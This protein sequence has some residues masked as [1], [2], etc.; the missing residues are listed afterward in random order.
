MHITLK[1]RNFADFYVIQLRSA[2][3]GHF[4]RCIAETKIGN[5]NTRVIMTTAVY[6]QLPPLKKGKT[7][8][9]IMIT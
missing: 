9:K 6:K 2:V 4:F 1:E 8:Q 3:H 7:T 5:N